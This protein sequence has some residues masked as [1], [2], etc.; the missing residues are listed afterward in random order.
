MART[1]RPVNPADGPIQAFAHD[2][3]VLREAAGNP[4]Y[5][6]LAKTAGFSATTL[7]DA[8]G[9][10]R[11]PTL[12]VTLAYV[13][14]CGGDMQSWQERW[15]A[16]DRQ[17]AAEGEGSQTAVAV[18]AVEPAETAEADT[19]AEAKVETQ[20]AI[21]PETEVLDAAPSRWWD[22]R[23]WLRRTSLAATAALAVVVGLI[24]WRLPAQ[25]KSTTPAAH[26]VSAPAESCPSPF[27]GAKGTF[28]GQ[29]YFASTNVRAGASQDAAVLYSL[30]AKCNLALDGYCLGDVIEDAYGGSPDMRW[31]TIKGGGVVSSAVIH[32]N[33]PPGMQPGSCPD[34]V[35]LPSSISLSIATGS[36]GAGIVG[37]Q[38]TG[39]GVWI[40]GFAAY[41][42]G[43]PGDPPAWHQVGTMTDTPGFTVLLRSGQLN[44]APGTNEV[45]VITVACL[46]GNGATNVYATGMVQL[47][48]PAKVQP[49]SIAPAE[50]AAAQGA[51]CHYPAPS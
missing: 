2:L 8:A 37:L 5:R 21:A 41:Y 48:T 42:P 28:L 7:G 15:R 40:A 44:S 31:F 9:G 43:T 23:R 1:P 3:R 27:T 12:E 46:G 26:H 35:P 25:A 20:A 33:P 39:V 30:P 18:D 51:A 49:W 50:L 17:L 32:G 38:A 14:A 11:L 29:T 36:T 10:V 4:T 34:D 22:S 16:L 19:A 6:V 13:G 47:T 24:F 45:P